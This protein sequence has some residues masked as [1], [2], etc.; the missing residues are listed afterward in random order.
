MPHQAS[1][2]QYRPLGRPPARELIATRPS[3]AG[4]TDIPCRVI[5]RRWRRLGSKPRGF[6]Q[7]LDFGVQVVL[8]LVTLFG[9]AWH[10]NHF[11]F[12]NGRI[13]TTRLR[14]VDR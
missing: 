13:Y 7:V 3:V 6:D 2:S 5:T 4:V 10:L 14:T 8:C 1:N 12:W 11:C 9:I